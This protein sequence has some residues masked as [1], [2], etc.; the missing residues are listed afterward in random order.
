MIYCSRRGVVWDVL[1]NSRLGDVR[2]C[3]G[4]TGYFKKWQ[5]YPTKPNIKNIQTELLGKTC[6]QKCI[7]CTSKKELWEWLF[8]ICQVSLF[9]TSERIRKVRKFERLPQKNGARTRNEIQRSFYQVS[10]IRTLGRPKLHFWFSYRQYR[11]Q[12]ELDWKRNA[13]MI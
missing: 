13:T 8:F 5:E 1:E 3:Y 10:G 2:K 11:H 9:R 6:V 4:S 7:L 12:K